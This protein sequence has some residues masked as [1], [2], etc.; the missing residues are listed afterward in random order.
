M[1]SLIKY[2]LY[3]VVAFSVLV[4]GAAEDEKTEVGG[5]RTEDGGQRTEDGDRLA[6]DA[7]GHTQT[8][9]SADPSTICRSYG[10]G[11]AE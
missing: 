3:F 1:N 5:Q 11:S 4:F 7:R 6:A 9:Y 8:F 2:G 10:A